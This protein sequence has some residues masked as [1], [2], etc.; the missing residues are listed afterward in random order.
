MKFRIFKSVNKCFNN[1][2]EKCFHFLMS[3]HCLSMLLSKNVTITDLQYKQDRL[4]S[5]SNYIKENY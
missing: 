1:E 5:K 2:T 4:V 3:E